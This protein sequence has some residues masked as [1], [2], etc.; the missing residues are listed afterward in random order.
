[1]SLLININWAAK[2]YTDGVVDT[3]QIGSRKDNVNIQNT[4]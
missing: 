1:M 2:T 3:D 4:R